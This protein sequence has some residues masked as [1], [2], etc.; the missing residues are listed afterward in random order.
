MKILGC[1]IIASLMLADD[2]VRD[3]KKIDDPAVVRRLIEQ[4]GDSSFAVR[5]SAMKKLWR[6]GS[7]SKET[8]ARYLDSSDPEA[9]ARV[10]RII[11]HMEM[12]I[13]PDMP[14]P[15]AQLVYAFHKST[16]DRRF[17]ILYDLRDRG[18]HRWTMDL[19]M[20]VKDKYQRDYLAENVYENGED[21]A[22]HFLGKAGLLNVKIDNAI[23]EQ[24]DELMD[25]EFMWD[26]HPGDTAVYHMIRGSIGERINQ[27]TKSLPGTTDSERIKL[28]WLLRL[29]GQYDQAISTASQLDS[30]RPEIERKLLL[31][32]GQWS[33]LAEIKPANSQIS[34]WAEQSQRALYQ[35]W[36]GNHD[37]FKRNVEEL[38]KNYPIQDY[39]GPLA[40]L[41]LAAMNTEWIVTNAHKLDRGFAFQLLCYMQRFESAFKIAGAP[42]RWE[43]RKK[44]FRQQVLWNLKR[45]IRLYDQ[46]NDVADGRA[47]EE[48]FGFCRNFAY[49]TGVLGEPRKALELFDL[50]IEGIQVRHGE[51]FRGWN[52]RLFDQVADLYVPQSDQ[53]KSSFQ[54]HVW[55]YF[56]VLK[57]NEEIGEASLILF[58]NSVSAARIW[59]DIL[60]KHIPDVRDRFKLI[61]S[62]LKSPYADPDVEIELDRLIDLAQKT[63]AKQ[64]RSRRARFLISLAK[65]CEI[66]QRPRMARDLRMQA[67]YLGD[68]S[69]FRELGEQ[70]VKKREWR[71]ALDWLEQA[72]QISEQNPDL[73]YIGLIQQLSGE[74]IPGQSNLLR[75]R[76]GELHSFYLAWLAKNLEVVG[77][78]EQSSR[79]LQINVRG[80]QFGNDR[81]FDDH[82]RLAIF[83]DQRDPRRAAKAWRIA[84]LLYLEYVGASA[85][86]SLQYH[87]LAM[88]SHLAEARALMR[89]GKTESAFQILMRCA[90]FMASDT[91]V[92][93]EF[94][95]K[96]EQAGWSAEANQLFEYVATRY[97][98]VLSAFPNSALHN[99]NFAWACARCN[100]RPET[101]LRCAQRAVELEPFNT[102]YLDTLAEVQFLSG[103]TQTAI[104][105][106][107]KCIRLNPFKEHY[108]QQLVRFEK[109]KK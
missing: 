52:V 69:A 15:I 101:R 93:E 70:A 103:N 14:P 62:L 63:I 42:E 75:S 43:E 57:M 65:T 10:N 99:N 44:W 37:E 100:R 91:S 16:E 21:L 53:S 89:E 80:S 32:D 2:T 28:I 51:Y 107:K 78:D 30:P 34:L 109:A 25:H 18:H 56:D 67:G 76:I 72:Y 71:E 86:P 61:A 13:S 29:T 92:A 24:L 33:R 90:E 7:V 94:V 8:L 1:F 4:L 47:A 26:R 96:L 27:L 23:M 12:G 31:E 6:D 36:A 105:L 60:E 46:N 98:S 9:A 85:V 55:H 97:E 106:A 73:H 88:Q 11:E 81:N 68:A 95:P 104:E 22:G 64:T 50:L 84:T 82:Q 5:Q 66:H 102:S 45:K 19:I 59:N 3:E 108:H 35:Y 17:A 41:N 48:L 54:E 79:L 49:Y 40:N 74:E 83:L 58:P 38:I 20:S 39:W 87:Y 77:D